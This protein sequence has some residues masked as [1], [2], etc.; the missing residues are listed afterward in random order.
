MTNYGLVL[1]EV[2]LVGEERGA[3]MVRAKSLEG[4]YG[5]LDHCDIVRPQDD[6]E[7]AKDRRCQKLQV[8]GVLFYQSLEDLESDLDISSV[9]LGT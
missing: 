3:V 6:V 2:G 9:T 4:R 5:R 7:D 1:G 8:L